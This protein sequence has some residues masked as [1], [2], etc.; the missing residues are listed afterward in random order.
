MAI[1]ED[2]KEEVRAKV[3]ID[4]LVSSYGFTLKQRGGELWCCCPFHN[5]KTP[6]FKVDVS[7]GTY[8]C[9]GCGESGDVFSFVM[10]QDGISF[11]DAIRKLASSVGVDIKSVESRSSKIRKRLYTLM[12]EIA[13][14]FNMMLKSKK[15][16]DAEVAREYLKTRGLGEDAVNRFI[17]GYAPKDVDKILSW[18]GRHGYSYQDLAAAGI[19]KASDTAGKPPYFYFS[20]RLVFSIKDR[21][22]QVVAFSG[23]Q[24]VEDKKSGK[25]IN[26]PETIIFKKS[27]TFFAFDEAR[28]YIVKSPNREAIICEGQID[29]IR[30]HVNGFNTAIAPLG[31]AFTEDHAVMLH[32]VADSAILCFDDDSAGHNA[33]I[34]AAHLLLSEGMPIRVLALP[35]GHDPDSFIMEK[36]KDAF[37][38]IIDEGTESIVQYQIRV[39][40]EA[41]KDPTE[42]NAA[43]RVTKKVIETVSKCKDKVQRA[44]LLKEASKALGVGLETLEGEMSSSLK[45]EDEKHEETAEQLIEPIVG[46]STADIE[47]PPS[48][49]E[50]AL[51]NYVFS[52]E[53]NKD[54]I[55][56]IRHLVPLSI[57]GSSTT[58]RILAAVL[59][60]GE[61]RMDK[62]RYEVENLSTEEY[63][64][65]ITIMANLDSTTF[66]SISEKGK[67]LYFARQLW[68]DYL[69][70]LL[71]SWNKESEGYGIIVNAIKVLHTATMKGV[72]N[73]IQ[74]FP[75]GMYTEENKKTA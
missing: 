4:D 41:E 66:S 54:V 26:S 35:D 68:H 18:A 58:R 5:E 67:V 12:S 69:V 71:K 24:L 27:R 10:K 51:I 39:A 46:G 6:S 8:H 73:L 29:C 50:G 14:D 16:K 56:Y 22:G 17:I 49:I 42:T 53:G 45:V 61:D 48:A 59:S 19:I 44:L 75:T 33:T 20:N 47:C 55:G 9:F 32:R 52:N 2:Q 63:K 74:T 36:G 34:K 13:S 43:L 28:K 11:G 21:N 57:I 40:R 7:R 31:T 25:Y 65:F 70:R 37:S 3:N 1:S 62:I 64:T 30:L 23:R 60:D 72:V 38:K 15:C